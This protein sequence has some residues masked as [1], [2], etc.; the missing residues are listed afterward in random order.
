MGVPEVTALSFRKDGM[1]MCCGLN[2]GHVVMY[3]IRSS[4]ALLVKDHLYGLPIKKIIMDE[5]NKKVSECNKHAPPQHYSSIMKH[6]SA[7]LPIFPG[8]KRLMQLVVKRVAV[9]L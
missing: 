7:T 4:K 2:T 9:N 3:D 5:K 6:V 8:R 1:T